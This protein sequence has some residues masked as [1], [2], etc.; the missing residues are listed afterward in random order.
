MRFVRRNAKAILAGIGATAAYLAGVLSGN[1]GLG[2]VTTQEWLTG[3]AFVI[4][5]YGITW[6]VPNDYDA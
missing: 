3:V 5:T 1:E 2:T 4:G 6:R